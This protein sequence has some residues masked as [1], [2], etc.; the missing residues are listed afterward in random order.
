MVVMGCESPPAEGLCNARKPW[1]A[2]QPPRPFSRSGTIRNGLAPTSAQ[3]RLTHRRHLLSVPVRGALVWDTVLVALQDRR[4]RGQRS[5]SDP[6]AL[7][8][9]SRPPHYAR[10]GLREAPFGGARPLVYCPGRYPHRVDPSN[11]RLVACI[12]AARRARRR[13]AR[14]TSREY[15][16]PPRAFNGLLKRHEGNYCKSRR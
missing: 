2:T 1:G 6:V 7:P 5:A 15:A 13:G 8:A 10:D 9:R 4:A 16:L 3:W 14:A 11:H 12:S